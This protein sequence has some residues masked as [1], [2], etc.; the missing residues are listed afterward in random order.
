MYFKAIGKKYMFYFYKSI[1]YIFTAQR[2]DIPPLYITLIQ[3]PFC[4]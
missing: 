2:Y 1:A 4:S 3:R